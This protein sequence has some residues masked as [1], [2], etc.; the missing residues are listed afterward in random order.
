MLLVSQSQDKTMETFFLFKVSNENIKQT[1]NYIL[2][3]LKGKCFKITHLFVIR[4][5]F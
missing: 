3:N 2:G 5:V 4:H 1:I